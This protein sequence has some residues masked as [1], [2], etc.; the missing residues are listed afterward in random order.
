MV[1]KVTFVDGSIEKVHANS[2]LEAR[3]YAVRQFGARVVARV[4]PAG[5]TDMANPR[6]QPAHKPPPR[7]GN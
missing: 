4:E 7:Q 6:A 3:R 1:F 2:P 5:L